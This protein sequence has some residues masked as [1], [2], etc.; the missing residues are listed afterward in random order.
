MKPARL[1]HVVA[2]GVLFGL[3]LVIVFSC[4]VIF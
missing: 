2:D 1:A 3:L 4:V